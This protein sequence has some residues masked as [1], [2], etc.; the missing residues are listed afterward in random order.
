[1]YWKDFIITFLKGTPLYNIF[2]ADP[3]KL[4]HNPF[5]VYCISNIDFQTFIHIKY[6]LFIVLSPNR[7]S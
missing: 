3:S 4:K 5:V 6:Q 7:V 2:V 1:M